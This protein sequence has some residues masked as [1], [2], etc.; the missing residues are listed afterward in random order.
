LND[1]STDILEMI[2]DFDFEVI[3]VGMRRSMKTAD[4]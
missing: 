1:R 3:S 4:S 2:L